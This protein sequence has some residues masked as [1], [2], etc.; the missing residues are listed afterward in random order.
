MAVS[1]DIA[2][3]GTLTGAGT[4]DTVRTAT[5]TEYHVVTFT[6]YSGNTVTLDVWVNGTADQNLIGPPDIDMLTKETVVFN[7]KLGNGD[8]IRAEASAANSI[9]YTD[10]MDVLS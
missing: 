8:T 1:S 2:G 9:V 3:Q 4:Q 6:N 10:E 5:G 7:I